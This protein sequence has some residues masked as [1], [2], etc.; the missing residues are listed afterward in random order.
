MN[1]RTKNKRDEAR[2]TIYWPG[3]VRH[4][5]YGHRRQEVVVMISL[6]EGFDAAALMN[7]FFSL[8]A[9]FVG[10]GFIIACGTLII[11]YFKTIDFH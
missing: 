9:P 4:R 1:E 5:L 7:D 11:N 3:S 8:A 10:I 2:L 6:P